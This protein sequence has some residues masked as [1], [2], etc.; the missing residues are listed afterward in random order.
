VGLKNTKVD[1]PIWHRL[2]P[3][4]RSLDTKHQEVQAEVTSIREEETSSIGDLQKDSAR[5]STKATSLL[6]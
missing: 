4:T 3:S 5:T 1:E 2:Q 6:F